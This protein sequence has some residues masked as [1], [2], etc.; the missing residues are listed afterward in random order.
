MRKQET[1]ERMTLPI[2]MGELLGTFSDLSKTKTYFENLQN[3][4][5]GLIYYNYG[6]IHYLKGEYDLALDNYQISYELMISDER[7]KDSA[8]VL[9]GIG[10]VYDMKKDFQKAYGNH[11]EVLKIRQ[12]YYPENDVYI[13]ISLYNIGRTLVNMD[14]N[15]QALIYHKKALDIWEQVLP[16]ND[17]LIA[18]SLHSHGVVY[19]NNRDYLQASEYY[20][21]AL[22]LYEL[23]TPRDHHGILMIENALEQI[24]YLNSRQ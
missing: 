3:E 22:Q 2:I 15:N 7:I 6:Y 14:D 20:T 5:D 17:P 16:Y 21:R 4:D 8:F 24:K 23:T 11:N 12:M 19:F 9:H 18:Q 10:Y 13:G 1:M